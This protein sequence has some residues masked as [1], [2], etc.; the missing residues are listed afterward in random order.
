LL[1]AHLPGQIPPVDEQGLRARRDLG[2]V[3]QSVETFDLRD[4]L[5]V[6]AGHLSNRVDVGRAIGEG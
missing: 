4:D 5:D 6:V 1:E 2:Q 3:P